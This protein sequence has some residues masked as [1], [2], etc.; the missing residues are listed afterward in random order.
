MKL[1]ATLVFLIILFIYSCNIDNLLTDSEVDEVITTT[2]WTTETHS[3]DVEPDYD[4]VFNNNEVLEFNITISDEDWEVMMDDLEENLGSSDS[5]GPPAGGPGA[6]SPVSEVSDYDPI[7]VPG[8]VNV[9]DINWYKVGIR[10]KGNSSL[11]NAYQSGDTKLS[12]KLDFDEFEDDYPEIEDQRFYGFRQL[13]LNNNYD[14]NSLMREKVGADLFREF[15]LISSQTTFC[16]LNVD[17][18]D[19]PIFYGVYT[20]V[21]EMDD[22]TIE[23]Q[24]GDDSGNLYKPDGDAASFASGTYSEDEM[25]KKNNDEVADYTDVEAL[26]NIINSDLRST[27]H[28]SW[29]TTLEE[30]FNVDGFLKWLAV[31]STIQNWDTYGN[32]THNYYLYNNHETGLLNWIPWDNNESLQDGKGVLYSLD[33]SE[34][35]EDWPLIKYILEDSDYEEIY[36][37]YLS[38]F[39]SEV[40]IPEDMSAIYTTYYNLIK[41]YA[42]EEGLGNSFDTAIEELKEHVTERNTVAGEY[43]GE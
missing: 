16:L 36:K 12:F 33:Y 25:E 3:R 40:F 9:N 26:Y 17:Y 8:N 2:D 43:L 23:S 1:Y 24:L 21:E 11:S 19:G 29:K 20:L 35:T 41:D 10:F 4:T 32:M 13:N 39:I 34:I 14:D 18:G 5:M 37:N 28:E 22:T 7:W 15:G 42:D 27:D 6:T 31:N 30:V 38:E